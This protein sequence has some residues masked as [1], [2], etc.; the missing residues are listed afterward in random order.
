MA[1]NQLRKFKMDL[2]EDSKRTLLISQA[3]TL[4]KR[5]FE[6]NDYYGQN[7]ELKGDIADKINGAIAIYIVKGFN[8]QSTGFNCLSIEKLDPSFGVSRAHMEPVWDG[9]FF[10]VILHDNDNNRIIVME[11]GE[12]LVKSKQDIRRLSIVTIEEGVK[13]T[14]FTSTDEKGKL[15]F[16]RTEDTTSAGN[17]HDVEAGVIDYDQKE[18]VSLTYD[19]KGNPIIEDYQ[20][21]VFFDR[22]IGLNESLKM[23]AQTEKLDYSWHYNT[24]MGQPPIN[25]NFRMEPINTSEL[26]KRLLE[27]SGYMRADTNYPNH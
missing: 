22:D 18:R 15:N 10:R 1:E 7:N 8:K 27:R 11:M 5:T 13:R 26:A 20:R 14:V 3:K 12:E 19:K 16:I 2:S 6:L 9:T 24:R 17:F 4:R 21:T 23:N 25:K